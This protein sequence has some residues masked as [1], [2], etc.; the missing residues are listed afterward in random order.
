MSE[1]DPTKTPRSIVQPY[2]VQVSHCGYCNQD[3]SSVSYGVVSNKMFAQ[4]YEKL[5]LRGWRR[6]GTYFYKPKNIGTCCPLY[7]IRTNVSSFQLSKT[8]RQVQRRFDR[9]L[10]TGD[11]HVDT[12]TGKSK[13][14]TSSASTAPAPSSSARAIPAHSL[15]VETVPPAC[16]AERY[17]LYKKYQIAVHN[18]TEEEISE[19]QFSRFLV[20]SPLIDRTS[21]Q[22]ST[23]SA[24]APGRSASGSL[25][26]GSY[27]QLYRIDGQL[28]ALGVVDLLPTGLSAVYMVYD[29]DYKHLVLGKYTALCELQF[30][31]ERG[32]PYYY[33]GFY[34]DGCEKMK[35]K[36]DFSPS[37]LLC[38]VTY[39][40]FDYAS[41]CKPK[42]RL[43]KFAPFHPDWF[44]RYGELAAR[45]EQSVEST[46]TAVG[47]DNHS[48]SV[49]P[50]PSADHWKQQFLPVTCREP[51]VV[52]AAVERVWLNVRGPTLVHLA[53]LRTQTREVVRPILG[54]WVKMC[55]A[56]L[57]DN[58]V[59]QF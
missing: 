15:T 33:M 48:G 39:D 26:Y 44:S 7:T 38:P 9:Y 3:Q 21:S 51:Q 40:W 55:G 46:S 8:Q 14:S 50:S 42:L 11:V 49:D 25:P 58:F 17:Q 37:E 57:A 28:V 12:E 29:P 6:S 52:S 54:E 27:H 32:L 59:V 43:Y 30:C 22:S 36:A 18:D 2:G 1:T 19:L 31:R 41:V 13:E 16:T 10:T 23:S 24:A 45:Q 4:D 5:M 34:I 20:Q 35:Y 47:D 56:D 53:Q